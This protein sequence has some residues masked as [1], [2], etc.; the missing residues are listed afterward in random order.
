ML[1]RI[2]FPQMVTWTLNPVGRLD[3]R[4]NAFI[5]TIDLAIGSIGSFI[6]IDQGAS[7]GNTYS[8]VRAFSNGG[9]AFNNLILQSSSGNVGIGTTTPGEKLS[10]N[11]KIRSKEVKVEAANWPD[12]VFTNGYELPSL[13]ETEKQIKEQGHLPGIPSASEVKAN[14]IDLGEMN[15][16]L[17]KKIEELTLYLIEKDKAI[18]EQNDSINGL[19]NQLQD[20]TKDISQMKLIINKLNNNP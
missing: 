6:Q 13:S 7:T 18:K 15:A 2:L 3:V 8:Q 14:G 10:V 12:Y 4:G 1:K 19:K 17:L 9:N 16:R 5:G 20:V 11:G